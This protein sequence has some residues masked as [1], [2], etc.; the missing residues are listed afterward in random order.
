MGFEDYTYFTVILEGDLVGCLFT[1]FP[2]DSFHERPSGVYEE[3]GEE[4]IVAC[5]Q[6]GP[7]GRLFTSYHFTAKFD[8]DGNQVYGRC[9]HPVVG[10][11]GGFEGTT[12]RLDFKDN[13]IDGLAVDFSFRGHLKLD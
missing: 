12:G 13:I 9:Q 6:G 11:D 3:H 5:L 8:E 2:P 10:A 1:K 4:V 7:C